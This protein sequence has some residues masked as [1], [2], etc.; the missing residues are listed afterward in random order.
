MNFRVL[1]KSICVLE[2]SSKSLGNLFLKKVRTLLITCDVNRRNYLLSL[3][4]QYLSVPL[5]E[6]C[7]VSYPQ[8]PMLP[9]PE[10][11]VLPPKPSFHCFP[12][13]ALALSLSSWFR[14]FQVIVDTFC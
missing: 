14:L 3:V 10:F 7:T 2:K 12:P 13:A 6:N 8:Q 1:E 11:L 9:R 5:M 4:I